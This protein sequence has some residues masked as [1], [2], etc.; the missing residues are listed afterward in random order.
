MS[1]LL[2]CH[3]NMSFE[4]VNIQ[5]KDKNTPN[6][7]GECICSFHVHYKHGFKHNTSLLTMCYASR[8][9]P[10]VVINGI[11]YRDVFIGKTFQKYNK[12]KV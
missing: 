2:V 4:N 10:T 6:L 3:E 8:K 11:H 7:C 12:C 5:R 1:G 9:L